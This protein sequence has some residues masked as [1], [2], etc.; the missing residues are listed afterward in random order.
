LLPSHLA[1]EEGTQETN[2][3]S[4][5]ADQIGNYLVM[6]VNKYDNQQGSKKDKGN[7]EIKRHAESDEKQG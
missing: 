6:D 3:D 7:A 1:A 5:Q 2:N 4:R